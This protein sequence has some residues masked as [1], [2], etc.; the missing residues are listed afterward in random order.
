MKQN[1]YI[2][3]CFELFNFS[4][5][6]N[7]IK[8]FKDMSDPEIQTMVCAS[9][10]QLGEYKGL[11]RHITNLPQEREH[12]LQEKTA[13]YLEQTKN[14]KYDTPLVDII[15]L[16][17][18]REG[19]VRKAL[20]ELA[21]TD[22]PNYRLFIADNGSTDSTWEEVQKGL[23]FFPKN[24]QIFSEQFP[25][26]IGRP[27]GHNWLL[28][29]FDHSDAEHIALADDD[30]VKI[31]PT[32]L[33][34]M[35]KLMEDYPKAAAVGGK[36]LNP[37]LPKVVHGGI[38]NFTQFSS[39]NIELTNS[40]DTYDYGQFDFIDKV[41]HVIGCL[42]L[43]RKKPLFDDIGL[44][45]IRFSPVQFV[46]IEHHLRT[47]LHGYDIIFNGLISFEHYREFGKKS[48]N[49]RQYIGNAI[50]NKI[51]ILYKYD[52]QEIN[53]LLSQKQ[54]EYKSWLHS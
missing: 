53:A 54:A 20:Q 8:N 25:T 10:L 9:F 16:T 32:W 42:Q 40:N 23:R 46:D 39:E 33:K 11:F 50:G 35:V 43:Y 28:A 17:C 12:Q 4:K 34:D 26:N 13:R 21:K 15:L 47:K 14:K 44:F 52:L 48:K 18:N 6:E 41:D 36:A 45:D 7:I 1:K 24:V 31:P 22:Y 19:Y 51:K 27:A 30:L 5:F 49:D 3:E 2:Q 38:R 37:G 29:K